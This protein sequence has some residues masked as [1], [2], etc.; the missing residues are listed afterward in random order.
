MKLFFKYTI[1]ILIVAVIA[2]S[3][4]LYY[5]V[6]QIQQMK[7]EAVPSSAQA[8]LS[9]VEYF[10]KLDQDQLTHLAIG[11]SII[12][13]IGS[14]EE[15]SFVSHFS[16]QLQKQTG[17]SVELQNEGI[18]GINSTDLNALVQKGEF[19]EQIKQADLITINVGGN[20]ILEALYE[21][22]Y[23]SVIQ[24]FDSMQSTFTQNLD[25]MSKAIKQA[26][27]DATIVFLEMYNPLK[28]DHEY[29]SLADQLLPK[30]NV[31]IYEIAHQLNHTIV[32]E[33]TKVI[34]SRHLQY[35]SADGVH[36]NS[37]G[38][39]ALSKQMLK[40]LKKKPFIESA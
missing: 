32:L 3:L 19:D 15:E 18:P 34:N 25:A 35:L 22:D 17:K 14:E 24:N 16:R 21:G 11:D 20:D 8:A 38:Y 6:Y 5:P 33:T 4:W 23:Q 27:P 29:Y 2:V 36:P 39:Q 26:N 28:Q 40:Q 12:T 37:L 31:K 9:Y 1:S 7:E 10:S 30:W 13:G